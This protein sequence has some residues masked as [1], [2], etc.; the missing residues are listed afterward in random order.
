[1]KVN[2]SISLKLTLMV[3]LL[4]TIIIFSS[5]YINFQMQTA[6]ILTDFLKEYEI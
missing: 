6:N 3:V 5:S 1:M 2:Y 4:S